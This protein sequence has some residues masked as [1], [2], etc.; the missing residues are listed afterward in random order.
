MVSATVDNHAL[1]TREEA[2]ELLNL[3]PQTLAAWACTGKGPP[4]VRLGRAVRYRMS[5][6]QSFIRRHTSGGEHAA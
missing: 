2:A 6:L 4:V 3:R 5:D 1:L